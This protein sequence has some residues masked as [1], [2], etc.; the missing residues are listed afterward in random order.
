MSSSIAVAEVFHAPSEKAGSMEL[1]LGVIGMGT[2]AQRIVPAADKAAGIRV[3]AIC[4]RLPEMRDPVAPRYGARSVPDI[5][6]WTEMPLEHV[7]AATRAG[8]HV[9]CEKP[10]ATT[11]A[12]A[13]AMIE[14]AD[15]AGVVF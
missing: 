8:K 6:T 14:A 5:A 13:T 9:L 11:L 7:R 4:D 2:A 3:A 1:R 15:R 10:V 12:E